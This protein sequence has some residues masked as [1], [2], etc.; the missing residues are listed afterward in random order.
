[1]LVNFLDIGDTVRLTASWTF[2]LVPERRNEGFAD[3]LGLFDEG[4]ENAKLVSEAREALGLPAGE[5][6]RPWM[7][8]WA[9][10]F[11]Y[12]LQRTFGHDDTER[13]V[14]GMQLAKRIEAFTSQVTL[15]KGAV[16]KVDR[17][18]I[19]K[20]AGDFSSYSFLLDPD[21]LGWPKPQLDVFKRNNNFQAI[22]R[23]RFFARIEDCR[24][25]QGEV[26][27][28]ERTNAVED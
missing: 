4:K 11:V 27:Y 6:H 25:M 10:T 13:S 18:Y 22:Q 1:M 24:I 23:R 16:L 28:K 2:G 20:G 5:T 12:S 7:G 8:G 9:S 26:H 17:V 3:A 15:P 21:T 14:A 19:R